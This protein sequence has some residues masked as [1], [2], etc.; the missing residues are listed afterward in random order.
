MPPKKKDKSFAIPNISFEDPLDKHGTQSNFLTNNPYSPAYIELAASWSKLPLYEHEAQ[1]KKIFKSIHDNQVTLI[2]SGTGSG[3][4]VLVPKFLLKYFYEMNTSKDDIK[5]A[6][7]N[8]KTLTTIYNAEYAAKTLDVVGN[9]LVGYKFRGS[10]ENMASA[11]T[12]LLYVTDGLLLSQIMKDRNIINTNPD[13]KL[14]EEYSGV[15][16]DEVHER[17]VPIDLLLYFLKDVLKQ[18]PEF[19]LIIMS[20]TIDPLLFKK[21][22]EN[23]D[24]TFGEISVSGQS[25]YPITNHYLNQTEKI[26]MFNYIDIGIKII[27]KLLDTDE[28]GDILMFVTSQ[29][30]TENGCLKLKTVC[31]QQV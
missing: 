30:E 10:P 25:H 26:N 20:A 31:S 28:I 4:T 15:I 19:K 23:D 27:T 1:I 21:F 7:T 24:I 17:Q 12:K 11:N 6:I 18:R 22:Y 13:K 29:K 2:I 8:P 5:I 9:T 3:K 14:L 16:I